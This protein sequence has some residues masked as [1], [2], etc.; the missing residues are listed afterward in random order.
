MVKAISEKVSR[1][2]SEYVIV[3]REIKRDI[4]PAD[5]SLESRLTAEL[6]IPL[7]FL[8][9]AMRSVTGP[10]LA[11]AIALQGGLGVLP[12]TEEQIDYVKKVKRFKAGFVTN[13]IAVSPDEEINILLERE[14]QYG[15]STFPVVENKKLVGLITEKFYHPEH[16]LRRKVYERML[17]LERLVTAKE[18]ITLSEANERMF[19]SKIGVLPVVDAEGNLVSMVF[20]KD[21]KLSKVQYPNQ[22]VNEEDK[23]LRVGAAISTHPEDRERAEAL[24]KAGVDVLFI[25]ASQGYSEYQK[26]TLRD[27]KK[28]KERLGCDTPII[29]GNVVDEDGFKSLADSGCDGI[30]VGQGIGTACTTLQVK[31]TGRGQATAIAECAEARDGYYKETG[32]YIPICSDG[33]IKTTKDMAIAFAL[34]AD[35]VMMGGYFAGFAEAAGSLVNKRFRVISDEGK[36]SVILAPVKEY[37]GE[38]SLRSRNLRRY[39]HGDQRTFVVEG[40]EGYVP[41]KGR[42]GEELPKDVNTLRYILSSNGCRTIPEFYKEAK[43]ELSSEAARGEEGVGIIL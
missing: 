30:K 6:K 33:S 10:D 32:R 35:T 27:L 8:G 13:L 25:D 17:P 21:Y 9:A 24:I 12:R 40:E 5:V 3:P 43:L 20:M 4:S 26:D 2:F 14:G 22:F 15:Y 39:G 29:G 1:A 38:A 36:V 18:S 23:R 7:P 41:Y 42:L 19:E 16:D 31:G 28:I 37:W 11:T 34:G